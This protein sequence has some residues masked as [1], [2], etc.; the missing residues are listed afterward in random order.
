MHNC[1]SGDLRSSMETVQQI[2]LRI[3]TVLTCRELGAQC[4][5]FGNG[6]CRWYVIIERGRKLAIDVGIVLV[7]HRI[8]CI[9]LPSNSTLWEASS[10]HYNQSD[11]FQKNYLHVNLL[12]LKGGKMQNTASIV[13]HH[14]S[15]PFHLFFKPF[16]AV[17]TTCNHSG[18]LPSFFKMAP[19]AS[20]REYLH[21]TL[22]HL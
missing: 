22:R 15:I 16:W 1:L 9:I 8:C 20:E 13:M 4:T 19:M 17:M 3:A 6:H 18:I 11:N 14:V 12:Q 2:H 7:G 10:I 5:T 21:G